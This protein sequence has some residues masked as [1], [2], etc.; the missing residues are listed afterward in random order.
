MGTSPLRKMARHGIWKDQYRKPQYRKL[1][2]KDMALM[3]IMSTTLGMMTL[4]SLLKV[5]GGAL[6]V[7]NKI[8]STLEEL[9]HLIKGDK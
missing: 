9:G 8:H 3:N 7:G 2:Y 6:T 5:K 4:R 1:N